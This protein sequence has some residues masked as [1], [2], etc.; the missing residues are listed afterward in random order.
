MG[1]TTGA[2]AT[3]IYNAAT[4]SSSSNGTHFGFASGQS[5]AIL[6]AASTSKSSYQFYIDSLTHNSRV[7]TFYIDTNTASSNVDYFVRVY[8]GSG[9]VATNSMVTAP[10]STT[11]LASATGL[12][13]GVF[14]R[15]AVFSQKTDANGTISLEFKRAT[16]FTTGNWGVVGVEVAADQTELTN[17]TE[18]PQMLE[19]VRFDE[20]GITEETTADIAS[21][22]L[23]GLLLDEASVLAAR[24]QAIAE[25][26]ATGI[27]PEQLQILQ[28]TPVIIGDLAQTGQVGLARADH[29]V[30]DD[31]AMGL[32]WFVGGL[33]KEVPAGMM[34][35]LTVM[36]HEFGHRLGYD[37]LDSSANSGHIMAGSL[38]PGERRSAITARTMVP[39]QP[40]S[41][42]AA[43]LP[44]VSP[45]R[46][47]DLF[48]A[49]ESLDSGIASR[50]STQAAISTIPQP[51]PAESN[52]RP[53]Q[54]PTPVRFELQP[55]AATQDSLSRL[56]LLDD[57]FADAITTLDA[58][59]VGSERQ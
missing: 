11:S 29:I 37:D 23:Q 31:D 36:T 49:N 13:L 22:G 32:G 20:N 53:R 44:A 7:A 48:E 5:I 16:G 41:E 50:I 47:A 6:N 43:E 57:L 1:G 52:N 40:V 59:N 51:A 14:Q 54:Q 19:G 42:P 25:W 33:D 15:S 55:E 30:L 58:L 12:G 4:A 3:S 26:A 18:L 34:D 8:F 10:G 21:L 45:E 46:L 35:L 27:S 56:S 24:E 28:S 17:L 9:S 39:Q 38:L 2:Y